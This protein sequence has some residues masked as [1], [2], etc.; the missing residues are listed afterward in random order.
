MS[1]TLLFG[2]TKHRKPLAGGK[3]DP[4]FPLVLSTCVAGGS[5]GLSFHVYKIGDLPLVP[6]RGKVSIRASAL[7]SGTVR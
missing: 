3:E 6:L 1:F 2:K 4:G 7:H 5:V